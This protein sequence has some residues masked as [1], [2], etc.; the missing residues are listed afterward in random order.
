MLQNGGTQFLTAA[1]TVGTS[2]RA[3]RIFHIIVVSDGTA[4]VTVV[5]NGTT[6]SGTPYDSIL[7]I[8]SNGVSRNYGTTGTV[9]PAGC[10][11][12][13]DVHSVGVTVNYNYV[14]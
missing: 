12:D 8:V 7:G 1:G 3:V 6:S 11:I 2:G 14:S 9:F 10:Y 4:G 13:A 5:R